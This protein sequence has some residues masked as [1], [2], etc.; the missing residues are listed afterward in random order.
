MY[1]GDLQP[2]WD[3]S[4]AALRETLQDVQAMRQV[5]QQ[6]L[7]TLGAETALLGERTLRQG[8]LDIYVR[9]VTFERTAGNRYLVQ[10]A[11][12]RT[13]AIQGFTIRPAP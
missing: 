13:G 2:I 12:D 10:W 3:A 11:F 9:T 5:H 4:S 6:L 7:D 1:A 8:G